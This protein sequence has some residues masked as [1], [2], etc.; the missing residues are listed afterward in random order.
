MQLPGAYPWDFAKFYLIPSLEIYKVTKEPYRKHP[1]PPPPKK[2]AIAEYPA[3]PDNLIY[4]CRNAFIV[5][6][7]ITQ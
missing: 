6:G 7:G 1:P 5:E 3:I 4:M 2:G